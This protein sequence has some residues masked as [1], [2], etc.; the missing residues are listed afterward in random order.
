MTMSTI[1]CALAGV[2]ASAL[3]SSAAWAD[4][5]RGGMSASQ[6]F[7]ALPQN[8]NT[9][10]GLGIAPDGTLILSMPNF[11]NDHLVKRGMISA[12]ARASGLDGP[13]PI[14]GERRLSCHRRLSAGSTL[15][16]SP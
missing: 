14:G 8:A 15:G 16:Y 5:A 4:P 7:L 12:P 6:P 3:I 2:A 9:P 13:L 1:R 10:D 11:N